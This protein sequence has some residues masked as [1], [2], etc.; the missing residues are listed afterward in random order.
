MREFL[1]GGRA[2]RLL[3]AEGLALALVACGGARPPVE[4]PE[5]PPADGASKEEPAASDA[6][7]SEAAPSAQ[8]S[9]DTEDTAPAGKPVNVQTFQNALQAVLNDPALLQAMGRDP[10]SAEPILI[11]GKDLPSGLERAAATRPVEVVPASEKPGKK[12]LLFTRIELSADRGTFKYRYEATGAYGTTRVAY[13]GGAWQLKS[14]R[15]SL[16]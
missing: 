3:L 5:P 12:I 16:P 6:D 11:A 10:S 7:E 2:A 14:S 4:A 13:E 8:P 1:R 9:S 15:V